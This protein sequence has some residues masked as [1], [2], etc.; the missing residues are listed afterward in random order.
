MR[1]IHFVLLAHFILGTRWIFLQKSKMSTRPS[2]LG[3]W[4]PGSE[5]M[6]WV[7]ITWK[8]YNPWRCSPVL[9]LRCSSIPQPRCSPVWNI[10]CMFVKDFHCMFVE[11]IHCMFVEGKPRRVF[12]PLNT[13]FCDVWKD[14]IYP[15]G[16]NTPCQ[17]P[18]PICTFGVRRR[19]CLHNLGSA[20][21]QR[22]WSNLQSSYRQST[23]KT[24]KIYKR[25][26]S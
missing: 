12:F 7:W 3:S 8:R 18:Q 26:S 23:E 11:Y 21:D 10:H 16:E 14:L 6:E 4:N 1:A 5:N 9:Q 13:L 2:L 19:T 20:L 15:L 25:W 22:T 24:S 17:F